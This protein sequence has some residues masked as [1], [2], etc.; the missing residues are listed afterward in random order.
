MAPIPWIIVSE[1][2]EDLKDRRGLKSEW[3][4]IDENV[5]AEIIATWRAIVSK[6]ISADGRS[7]APPEAQRHVGEVVKL[8]R[9]CDIGEQGERA[10]VLALEDKYMTLVFPGRDSGPRTVRTGADYRF[11]VRA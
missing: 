9:D 2:I 1:I 3:N 5:R 7:V 4:G 11:L 10:V 6:W 8:V